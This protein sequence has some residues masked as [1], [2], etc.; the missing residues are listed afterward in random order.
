[1]KITRKLWHG[2]FLRQH[3][4]ILCTYWKLLLEQNTDTR[5]A[6][7]KEELPH[8]PLWH[9]SLSTSPSPSYASS[10]SSESFSS[11]FFCEL[12]KKSFTWMH[13]TRIR[14]EHLIMFDNYFYEQKKKKKGSFLY[15][16]KLCYFWDYKTSKDD[17]KRIT[18][19]SSQPKNQS[20]VRPCPTSWLV[21]P[22][23]I[24]AWSG[25]SMVPMVKS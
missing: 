8:Q 25:I 11:P 23:T 12:K 9:M 17:H 16:K 7:L 22:L 14:C 6:W 4:E 10:R 3:K 15:S 13:N 5:T 24:S 1:M 19:Q 21:L 2:I 20:L 18:A